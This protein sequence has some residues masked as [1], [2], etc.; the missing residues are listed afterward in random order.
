M[1]KD[2]VGIQ[3]KEISLV[4]DG[5]MSIGASSITVMRNGQG[6]TS[7]T[8]RAQFSDGTYLEFVNGIL[9]GGNTK[10]GAF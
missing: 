10:G 2:R 3:H 8:G 5:A 9:V 1:D 4:S 6:N 7:K